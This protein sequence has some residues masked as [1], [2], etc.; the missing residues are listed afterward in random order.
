MAGL[1]CGPGR[2]ILLGL[3]VP[4]CGPGLRQ[5]VQECSAH[6][7]LF[8]GVARFGLVALNSADRPSSRAGIGVASQLP[9]LPVAGGMLWLNRNRLAGSYLPFTATSRSYF[10]GPHAARTASSSASAMKL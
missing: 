5:V 10:S 3:P 1:A 4:L 6:R 7:G 8:G 9:A 2:C